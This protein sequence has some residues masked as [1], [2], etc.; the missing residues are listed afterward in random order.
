M[1]S[2]AYY[3]EK[4]TD[5]LTESVDSVI[6]KITQN[7]PQSLEHLQTGAWTRQIEI[8]QT[9]IRKFEEGHIF[10]EFQIPR[11]GKRADVVL[12]YKDLIF[13]IEFKVGANKYLPQDKRQA[14]GYAIDLHHF[15]EGSHHKTI[16]PVLVATNAIQFTLDAPS[17]VENVYEPICTNSNELH[18]VLSYCLTHIKPVESINF[19]TWVHAPYK[20]TPTII[21]AAQALYSNHDVS[22]ISRNDAGAQNLNSTTKTIQNIIHDSKLKNRKTI[23]FV[24]GV[25]GAGKTLAGLNIATSN[26]NVSADEQAIFLS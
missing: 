22:D 6:G 3:A 14:H 2:R 18:K 21:E 8:L 25:P 9:T 17:A 23:C 11:M 13:V 5:F 19:N 10:F 15:H 7:H 26:A 4:V 1:S 16:I 20:P 24:T 12:I